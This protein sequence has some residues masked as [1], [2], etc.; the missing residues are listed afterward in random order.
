M[1]D[2]RPPTL[3]GRLSRRMRGIGFQLAVVLTIAALPLSVIA[4]WL[5]MDFARET[6]RSAEVML[7]GMTSENVELERLFIEAGLSI[8]TSLVMSAVLSAS[9]QAQCIKTLAGFITGQPAFRSIR[10]VPN[11]GVSL[12]ATDGKPR[13]L[14]A[15]PAHLRF[16]ADP[17]PTVDR[18]G[19]DDD[20]LSPTLR[21]LLPAWDNGT[22]LGHL[23]VVLQSYHLPPVPSHFGV[24]TP[25]EVVLLNPE[26]T[27]LTST[28]DVKTASSHLPNTAELDRLLSGPDGFVAGR[29]RSGGE[30][31][32]V[33]VSLI[34]A[35]VVAL[36]IWPKDNPVSQNDDAWLKAITFPLLA[37]LVSMTTAFFA[38]RR[39][40]IRPIRM[41]RDEM[42]RFGLGQRNDAIVLAPG[43]ALEIQETVNTFNKLE[44]I[45]ARNEAALALT[46][47][48]KLLLLREVHHRIKNNLQMISSIISIHRRKAID[49][50]VGKV[51]R[52]LQDRVMS[53]A[54]VDQSLYTNG[55]VVDVR[56]DLLIASI[57][58]RLVGVNLEANHGVQ[59][60]TRFDTVMLHADQIG[61]LSL[62]VNEAITNALKHVGKP[63]AGPPSIDIVLT[64]DADRIHFSI[65]NSMG[66]GSN[67]ADGGRD[68]TKLGMALISAF[69]DQLA[70]ELQSGVDAADHK[71]RLSVRFRPNGPAMVQNP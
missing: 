58:D 24:P 49:P 40:V 29:D 4:I 37:W 38:I 32:F 64:W 9:D 66:S 34:P 20:G 33:K 19:P 57:S 3:L 12:C 54:A 52:S 60:S 1:D 42:R 36:G 61:P 44:V 43:A 21:V 17:V 47:E 27:I 53:I 41:L 5:S 11:D 14:R 56:A 48:G 2:I 7:M 51:L 16:L 28:L 55:D 70:A 31:G 68:S 50:E 35:S 63:D 10:F 22:L 46:T 25:L 67:V 15:D 71:F 13:D 18:G 6:R 26:G 59:I 65:A 69:A 8:D 62:L 45:V 30:F 23:T 39:L